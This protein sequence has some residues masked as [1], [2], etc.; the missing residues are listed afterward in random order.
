MRE[1]EQIHNLKTRVIRNRQMYLFLLLPLIYLIVFKYVPMV[2][3]QIAFR[4]YNVKDGIWGSPWVGLY[5]FRKFLDSYQFKR[6]LTNTITLS[7]YSL[8][9][10][11][12]FPIIM[13]LALNSI[14][15]KHYRSFIENV[16]YMPHFI[17]TVVM[18]GMILQVFSP[19]I[20]VY[21]ALYR[22][23]FPGGTVPD[24]LAS[25]T[26]FPHIY[27]WTGIWQSLGW[28][29]II[30][31]ASL[32]S[33][34]IQV[35][36]AAIIDGASRF[37]RIL[38]VDFPAIVPTIAI[39]LILQCGSLMNIGFDK[40]FLMQND[41]NLRASEVIS[42]YV[43]KVGIAS[44]GNNFSYGASIGLFNSAVNFVLI[45]IVNTVSRHV[46]GSSLW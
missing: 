22:L 25:A 37:R 1:R 45:I 19:R 12:P 9:A 30:Y 36:E 11:F 18:V 42:T 41:L 21:S 28:N 23:L 17:S 33:V 44:G 24:I 46:S 10:G 7:L 39:T 16:T 2:G 8:I 34:D 15:N 4:D 32:S 43:Y 5:H 27:V 3:A 26:A 35:H 13:A 38:H 29:S 40:V 6:V 20:G 31:M 14:R